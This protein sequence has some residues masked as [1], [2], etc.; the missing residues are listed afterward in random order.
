[1]TQEE[2]QGF[3]RDVE[4]PVISDYPRLRLVHGIMEEVADG[5]ARPGQY[6]VDGVESAMDEI[7]ALPW[8]NSIRRQLWVDQEGEDTM[9]CSSND[10]VNGQGEP[11][12]ACNRC[13]MADWDGNSPPA[14]ELS[15]TFLLWLP[16]YKT[17]AQWK[18][19]RS[20]LRTAG[21]ALNQLILSHGWEKLAVR[22]TS[23][24]HQPKKGPKYLIPKIDFTKMNKDWLPPNESQ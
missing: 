5:I 15:K 8:G 14:C 23:S 24:Q 1:M 17:W 6:L 21:K 2:M 16:E 4:D 19:R 20:A 7:V 13:P 11:G 9:M 22:I 12:G 10:G 3:N 18:L